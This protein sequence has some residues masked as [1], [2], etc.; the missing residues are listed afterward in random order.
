MSETPGQSAAALR[1]SEAFARLAFQLLF[2]EDSWSRSGVSAA[3]SRGNKAAIRIPC[4]LRFKA[5]VS[6]M[7][8]IFHRSTNTLSRLSLFSALF[9]VAL[10]LSVLAEIERSS[11]IT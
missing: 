5:R 10:F 7:P 6:E 2:V 1:H 11:Y 3:T 9:L 8:Q 4:A